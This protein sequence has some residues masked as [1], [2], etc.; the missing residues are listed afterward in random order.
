MPGVFIYIALSIRMVMNSVLCV[1]RVCSVGLSVHFYH[2]YLLSIYRSPG[3][4]VYGQ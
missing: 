2:D 1:E 4:I 3:C